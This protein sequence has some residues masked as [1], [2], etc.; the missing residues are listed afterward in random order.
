M[1]KNSFGNDDMQLFQL[2]LEQQFL[3]NEALLD[4]SPFIPV[5]TLI[6]INHSFTIRP[7]QNSTLRG[8]TR[9]PFSANNKRVID[10]NMAAGL[11]SNEM[12]TK[13][14]RRSR[15]PSLVIRN[16][17]NVILMPLLLLQLLLTFSYQ[18]TINVH[19]L[20]LTHSNRYFPLGSATSNL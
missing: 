8:S 12:E 10:K 17:Q 15:R 6:I 11:D 16:R 19:P 7:I 14:K 13:L 20:L 18:F 5:T 1:K 4:I 2:A 9:A 3:V